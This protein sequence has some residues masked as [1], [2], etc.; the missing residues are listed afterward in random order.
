MFPRSMFPRSPALSGGLTMETWGGFLELETSRELG[1]NSPRGFSEVF[2]FISINRHHQKE[3]Y[4]TFVNGM[5]IH[6]SSPINRDVIHLCHL[7]ILLQEFK[8]KLE[9]LECGDLGELHTSC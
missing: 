2:F 5:G 3:L 4:K 7:G 6:F 9:L 8:V 1:G